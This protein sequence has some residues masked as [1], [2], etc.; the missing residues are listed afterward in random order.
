MASSPGSSRF[1][2]GIV[3]VGQARS[4]GRTTGDHGGYTFGS[5]R[6]DSRRSPPQGVGIRDCYTDS[7]RDR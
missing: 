7:Q 1:G 6:R 3:R 5:K 2:L 4:L